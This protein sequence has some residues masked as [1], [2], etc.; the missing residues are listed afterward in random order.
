M[1]LINN[2]IPSQGFE[3]VRDAIGAILKLELDKQKSLQNLPDKNNVFIGRSTP[4]AHSEKLMINVSTDSASYSDKN[5]FTSNG[6]TKY[7]IDIYV[8]AIEKGDN[9]GG[10]ISTNLR[11]KYL[12]MIRYILENHHYVRLG[13]PNGLVMGT[14]VE[15]F[16]N[17][18]P[19]NNQDAS[20]VK[21]SRLSFSV[22]INESQSVWS[23]VNISS[24]FT[25]VK[26]A[27]TELGYKYEKLN[28]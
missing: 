10:K 16:D 22:R 19:Q 5:Q 20:F 12:G 3:I 18:E 23:G 1:S 15:G 17:Y 6:S 4:F 21:M 27:L 25:D 13:L 11:D 2:I 7:H 28:Q 14:T 24:I 8:K 26:L 9:D